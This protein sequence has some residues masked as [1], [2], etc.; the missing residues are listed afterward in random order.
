MIRG[1]DLYL[2]GAIAFFVFVLIPWRIKCYANNTSDLSKWNMFTHGDSCFDDNDDDLYME[3]VRNGKGTN[4]SGP[5]NYWYTNLYFV[6]YFRSYTHI[7]KQTIY[8]LCVFLSFVCR[9][10]IYVYMCPVNASV[11]YHCKYCVSLF[12]VS[13]FDCTTICSCQIR[14]DIYLYVNKY[15]NEKYFLFI[16]FLNWRIIYEENEEFGQ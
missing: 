2:F 10:F 14:F 3:F 8:S 1:C 15:A 4:C 5:Q 7:Y 16:S 12:A 11:S 6:C 13:N 9:R